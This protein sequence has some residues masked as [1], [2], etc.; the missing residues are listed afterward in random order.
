YVILENIRSL[1]NVGSAFRTS[2]G[3]NIRRL[4]LTGFSGYPPRK[5]ITKT[6]IGAEEN[7]DWEHFKTTAEAIEKLR[8]E[9]PGIQIIA[10]EQTKNSVLYTDFKCNFPVALIFGN[11]IMGVSQEAIKASDAVLH[12]PML[13]GKESLN[14]ATAYGIVLYEVLRQFNLHG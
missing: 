3:C 14:V 6:A 13:G 5:E 2:D 12:I 4:F 8:Q 10:V 11:E 9:V 1:Y 7:I